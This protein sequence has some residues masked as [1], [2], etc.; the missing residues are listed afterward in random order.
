[1]TVYV[2]NHV[3]E[4]LTD[5]TPDF[6]GIGEIHCRSADDALHRSFDSD[7]GRRLIYV[8]SYVEGGQRK[9]IGISRGGDWAN[10]LIIKNS[11]ASFAESG[12]LFKQNASPG[13][14][15][16]WSLQSRMAHHLRERGEG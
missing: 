12:G 16:L 6:D 8:S 15:E 1:M 11:L 7:E 2:Q 4:R 3:V 9:W 13:F 10:R 5:A 14:I